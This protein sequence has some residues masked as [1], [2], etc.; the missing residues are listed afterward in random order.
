MW[1]LDS[2]NVVGHCQF[3]IQIKLMWHFLWRQDW[4][5]EARGRVSPRFV[6]GYSFTLYTFCYC[7]SVKMVHTVLAGW[8]HC[9]S[10]LGLLSNRC[11]I[12][13]ALLMCFYCRLCRLLAN[14]QLLL[15]D[16]HKY[17]L[18]VYM[19]TQG[20][21]KLQLNIWISALSSI[22]CILIC[23]GSVGVRSF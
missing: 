18:V 10:F 19:I 5:P 4:N 13:T 3:I 14:T 9:H 1:P 23:L 17:W 15:L 12:Q 16:W 21:V 6:L 8:L 22:K 7:L 11:P 2:L 20:A